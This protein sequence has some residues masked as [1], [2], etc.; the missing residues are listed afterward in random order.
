MSKRIARFAMWIL[1]LCIATAGITFIWHDLQ[2]AFTQKPETIQKT[3]ENIQ[4]PPGFKIRLY[5]RVPGARSIA[6]G[7]QGKVV[8]VGTM[9]TKVF[10][11]ATSSEPGGSMRVTEFAAATAKK[12]PHGVCFS[13][14]GELFVAEQNR[15]LSFA[16]A[17][18]NYQDP[19][20]AP[21]AVVP[22]GALIPQKDEDSNHSARVCR[23]GPGNKLYISL[24]KPF[25]VPPREKMPEFNQCGIGGCRQALGQARGSLLRDRA[26]IQIQP[27]PLTIHGQKEK[28]YACSTYTLRG[29]NRG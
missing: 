3:L 15:V 1:V 29:S 18:T 19:K 21:K 6:V 4:L 20:I 23:A 9:G 8:F 17:E 7:P 27:L 5:A 22:Q 10:A 11:L 12:Y 26:L 13:R 14:V 24:G 28:L 16:A 2:R 25:N